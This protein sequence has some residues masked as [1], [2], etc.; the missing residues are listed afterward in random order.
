MQLD[1]RTPVLVGVAAV[2]QRVDEPGGG[3]DAVALMVRAAE[4]AG[5]DAGASAAGKM[6][7]AVDRVFVPRGLWGAGDPGRV[8]AQRFGAAGAR[9]MVAEIGVLQQTL[10]T[11]AETLIAAGEADVIMVAGAEAAYRERRLRGSGRPALVHPLPPTPPDRVLSPI[12][13]I[14][15]PM[16]IERGLASPLRQYAVLETA[17]RYAEELSV[18]EHA[19][20]VAELWSRFADE[21]VDNPDAWHRSPVPAR[22]IAEFSAMNPMM[23]RPYTRA[24]CSRAG[25]DQAAALLLC[26]AEAAERYGVP[27]DRWVF[28]CAAAESNHM[29]PLVARAPLQRSPG[30]AAVGSWLAAYTGVAAAD[31]TYID[32]Y[33]CFP[34]AVRVQI[35]ELGLGEREDL[36]VTGGMSFAGGPLNSYA[37]H[38]TVAMAK[39]LRAG[40]PDATG[41]VTCVSGM[42]TKQAGAMWSATPPATPFHGEDLSSRTAEAA[43]PCEVVGD[44]RGLGA[45]D[46]FTATPGGD[47]P[48]LAVAVVAVP[49]GRRTVARTSDPEVVT[50]FGAGEWVGRH[51]HVDGAELAL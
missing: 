49:G 21:A 3:L 29:V 46:G 32:L 47:G 24:H 19:T 14:L 16:E 34:S 4:A 10:L 18:D 9:T 43:I 41:L 37:L 36:T 12:G 8:I 22:E 48:P 13:D 42:L 51:V 33:S 7:G 25:V 11:H 45:V 50:A 28:P 44:Y 39:R 35:A 23:A 20:R 27:R 2:Q 26:S 38:A 5:R 1:P 6:L 30:F 31:A 40:E 15:H 17:L